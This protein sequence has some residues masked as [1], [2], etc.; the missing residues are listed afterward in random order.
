VVSQQ[1]Y[2]VYKEAGNNPFFT[3]TQQAGAVATNTGTGGAATGGPCATGPTP[4]TG[5]FALYSTR[6]AGISFGLGHP[7]A[8]YTRVSFGASATR[9]SQQFDASG[10]PQQFLDL[11]GALVS[12][13]QSQGIQGGAARPGSSRLFSLNAGLFRDDRDDPLSPRFGGTRSLSTEWSSKAFGSDYNYTKTDI[14]LTRFFP[15]KHHSSIALHFNYGFSSGGASLPYNDLF[16][17]T[18]Q[19]LRNTT[20]VFYGDRELLGQAELRIPVTQDRKFTVAFFADAG[21]VPYVTPVVGPSPSPTPIP[22][23]GAHCPPRP[24]LAASVTYVEAPF[25][26]KADFGF[27]IRVQTPIVPQPIRIDFAFGQGGHHVSF[28]LSQSF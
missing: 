1:P 8:D 18:D 2:P 14:D 7:V 26:L 15:V 3:I 24:P 5:E 12:P 9:L 23:C 6:Q 11:R 10:F 13:N 4:C 22:P 16:S 20:F 19:Q 25:H 28:G 17:L 21:D 27:G